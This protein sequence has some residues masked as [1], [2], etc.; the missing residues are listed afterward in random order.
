MSGANAS[1]PGRSDQEMSGANASPPG[2]SDQEMSGA[3]ASPPG[4]SHQKMQFEVRET[5]RD[6]DVDAVVV[7][8]P[9]GSASV[10]PKFAEIAGPFFE[11]GDLPL[12]ALDIFTTGR[13]RTIFI[14]IPRTGDAQ[15]WQRAAATVVRKV[16]NIRSVAFANGD[17]QAITEG[18]L[19][20]GFSVEL[21]KTTAEKP[22]VERVILIGGDRNLVNRGKVIAESINWARRLIVEPSNRKPPRVIAEW[23]QAMAAESG[24]SSVILTEKEIRELNMGA[25]LGVSQ[26]SDEP[27]RVVVLTHQGR[28]ESDRILAYVGKGITFDTGGISIKPADGMEKMKYDMAGGATAMAALRTLA[29]LKVPVNAMA[30][31]PLAENM[32]GGRAQRPGDVVETMAGK[33][34]EIINTDAEGRLVLAD[35]LAYAR[36]LGATHIVDL[37]TLTGAC[38]VALGSIRVAVMGN[39]QKFIDSFLEASKNACE[40]MWQF[41]MDDEYREM[42]KSSVADM[43]NSGGRYAGLM[44]AAKLLQEF[45]GD[46][47]WVHLDIAGTAWNDEEKPYLPKGPSGI[48]VRSLIEFA[49][50]FAQ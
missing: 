45:V 26:G 3:N 5:L 38:R 2:R 40:K 35:G 46:T 15:A 1:P 20:G 34:I 39:D 32:P 18:V 28:P 30:I 27:P 21:Y 25:L 19:I 41:P 24:L 43:A 47:P 8:I 7:G 16:K 17:S 13:P 29:L 9:E 50:K 48:A 44:T 36:R 31:V 4:R 42:I 10:D 12:K 6:L 33:T 37:A 22:K 23:A 49:V 11:S 14:G